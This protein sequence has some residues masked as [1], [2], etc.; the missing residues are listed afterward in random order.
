MSKVNKLI[1]GITYLLATA[2]G[3]LPNDRQSGRL[4]LDLFKIYFEKHLVVSFLFRI[5]AKK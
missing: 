1:T 3:Q 4:R 5:F 2:F